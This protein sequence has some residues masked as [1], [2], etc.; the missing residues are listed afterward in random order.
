MRMLRTCLSR[1][2]ALFGKFEQ[3]R[4][5]DAELRSHLEMHVADYLRDGMDPAEARRQA[6]IKLGGLEQIKENYRDRRGLPF[7]ETVLADLRFAA[8]TL[9]KNA[10]F[11]TVAVLTLALGIGANTAIFSIVNAVFLRP[12]PFPNA[13]RIFLVRRAGNQFG[14]ASISMPVFLAWQPEAD[15]FEHLGLVHWRLDASLTGAG[16][17]ER[18]PSE[19]ISPEFLPALG[20]E[21][22][23]GRNFRPDEGR[24]G[25]NNV[26][27]ISNH[28]WRSRFGA[29]PNTI[30]REL[31][32]DGQGYAVVGIL[33]K[34]LDIPIPGAHESEVFFAL[35][36]PVTSED[37]ANSGMLAIGL[38]KRG[39]TPDEAAAKLTPPL[40]AL[41]ARFPKLFVAGE[42]A[43]LMP[44][45]SMVSDSAGPAPLLLFGAVGLVLLIACANVGSLM[46]AR[47]TTRQREIAIRAAI[48]AGRRRIA[49]QLLTES[50]LIA[51][52]GGALGVI[53]CYASF[54]LI[55][56][57]V[58]TE[59]AMPHIGAYQI[60][61]TVLG[62][63]LLLSLATGIIF[64]FAPAVGASRADLSASL[65]EGGW[66]GGS[67]PRSRLRQSLAIAEIGVSLV[68]L[69]GAAL[70]LQSFA[71]LVHVQPGFDA[72]DVTT[73]EFS[74]P[75]KQYGTPAKR[76]AFIGEGIGRLAALPGAESVAMINTLPL[77]EGSDT[78]IN[79]EGRPDN[80]NEVLGAEIRGISPDLFRTLRIP[81]VRGRGFSGADNGQSQPVL[82][83]NEAMA[84]A[85]WPKG[86]A[87]G[88]H[89]WIGRPMGPRWAEPTAREV[90]GIVAN[91]HE[92]SLAEAPLPTM[93]LP[94][95]QTQHADYGYFLVRSA[96]PGAVTAGE[97]RD[98]LL[99]LDA[100]NP[101]SKIRTLEQTVTS[102]LT[103][104]RFRAVLLGIF[105]ALALFI[106]TIGV[107]GVISYWAAQRT[108]EIGI[109]VALG[110]ERRDIL[111]LI[112]GQ[113]TRMAIAG[114]V[115]G[116]L[117][118][119]GLASAMANVLYGVER[120]QP[121]M[122]YGVKATDPVTFAAA[123]LLLLLVTV[124]ACYLPARRAMR[125]D[126]LVALR[127]E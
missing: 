80:P 91:M 9:R 8:R 112:I 111:G 28:L 33:P 30:G 96:R 22:A 61:A 114:V 100:N 15:M 117:V 12:L 70:T 13:N 107:Y 66:R 124:L 43:Q 41:R 31:T 116:A 126:P 94:I 76:I 106:A 84:S 2:G 73:A 69:I 85:Y 120:E 6:L 71:S 21:P 29:D 32:L 58:P 97:I 19:L 101:P 27:L 102:S 64:G 113:G 109:R 123:S 118:T 24:V 36:V 75:E 99:K 115:M 68:L 63:A 4:E 38:L 37:P 49:R 47:S 55:L 74:L 127:C 59:D 40:A 67:V 92:S 83:I 98:A 103:D 77:R 65:Q 62:F 50:V 26:V 121:A 46:L 89:V 5:L 119:I 93:Y 25:G 10:G 20:V 88:A 108:H 7:I 87:L 45:R 95:G 17:S 82:M 78:L 90:V 52:L 54:H 11:T 86:D 16:E 81:V 1:I 60:D 105:A 72:T 3:D 104:W 23:L 14:G 53:L 79:I 48:G 42:R 110:A 51:L 57:L 35:Q 34:G 56:G 122:L 18:I 44:L 39:V 125:V